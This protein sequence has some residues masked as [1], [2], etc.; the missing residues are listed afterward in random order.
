MRRG[1]KTYY[2]YGL[3]LLHEE[4]GSTVRYYHCDRRGDT[5][6]L[7]GSRGLE[8]ERIVAALRPP[9]A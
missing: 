3:G 7:K 4:T 2:V 5:V 9:V 1:T 6:L 8:M